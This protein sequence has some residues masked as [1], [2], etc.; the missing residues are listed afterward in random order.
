[1]LRHYAIRARGHSDAS[2][3]RRP[4]TPVRIPDFH[5]PSEHVRQHRISR[6]FARVQSSVRLGQD[7]VSR[8]MMTVGE[9]TED[10]AQVCDQD[11]AAFTTHSIASQE[12]WSR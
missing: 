9:A 8:P 2:S 1:M 7:D 4:P 5:A 6:R 10:V 12:D 11:I 3:S